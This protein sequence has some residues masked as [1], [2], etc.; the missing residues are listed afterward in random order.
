M[1]TEEVQ[2]MV[3]QVRAVMNEAATFKTGKPTRIKKT[4]AEC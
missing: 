2:A 3:D 1:V 4:D